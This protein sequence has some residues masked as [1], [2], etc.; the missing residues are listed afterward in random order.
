MPGMITIAPG[1]PARGLRYR[2]TLPETA[3]MK[4]GTR[5]Y[6]ARCKTECGNACTIH[7][8]HWAEKKRKNVKIRAPLANNVSSLTQD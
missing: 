6:C 5:V 1:V 8:G 7:R 2:L 3:A 4:Y